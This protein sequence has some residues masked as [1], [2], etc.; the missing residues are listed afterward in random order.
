MCHIYVV[1]LLYFYTYR[2]ATSVL[3]TYLL[4]FRHES[5]TD[6]RVGGIAGFNM[7]CGSILPSLY[8]FPLS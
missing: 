3:L 2:D 7:M 4:C 8:G 1:F 5:F 6:G